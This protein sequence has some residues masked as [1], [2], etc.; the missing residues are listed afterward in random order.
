MA[1]DMQFGDVEQAGVLHALRPDRNRHF[2]VA[3]CGRPAEEDLPI[4]VDLDAMREMEEH[5]LSD[6]RVEL[7]GVML[8]GQH[9]DEQGRPFV[10][11]TDC[12]RAQHYQS[13]K[14]SF[15][16]THDTWQEI[17]RQ[18]DEFPENLQMVG[19]YH[20]HPSWGVFLSS[21]DMFI[22]QNFFNRPL[23]LA[24][25]I[26]PCRQDRGFFQ[27]VGQRK[28]RT[29]RTGGFYLVSS[30]FREEELHWY[31]A[32]L[33]EETAM[34][35]D[36]DRGYPPQRMPMPV[37]NISEGRPGWVG[38]AVVGMLVIQVFFTML[39]AWR[40]IAGPG[41]D[42]AAAPNV[43]LAEL[44]KRVEKLAEKQEEARR[45]SVKQEVLDDVLRQIGE[46]DGPERLVSELLD[47][48]E[49]N[50]RLRAA[51]VGYETVEKQNRELAKSLA[52]SQAKAENQKKQVD[53]LT[54]DKRTIEEE[55]HEKERKI[56]KLEETIH[57]LKYP[58]SDGEGDD[59]AD[60]GQ[61]AAWWYSKWFWVIVAAGVLA[62]LGIGGALISSRTRH[63]EDEGLPDS[64][65]RSPT[66][67]REPAREAADAADRPAELPGEEPP[68]E[69]G[70]P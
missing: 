67:P 57:R 44:E 65:G 11:V 56:A 15:K 43:Q 20:T 35:G 5:A 1:S 7:G 52:E 6:T 40:L 53:E 9:E 13:T 51:S 36:T 8:G 58:P 10:F 26:D 47:E 49:K 70:G 46:P 3:A 29:R 16:F 55:V 68:D 62:A 37:V 19:W 2:A 54:E 21:L 30:R 66:E 64:S 33:E 4:F 50:T 39:V 27:W 23:D 63:W 34:R 22:C 28:A 14:G 12:L 61:P 41:G 60:A 32:C 69:R 24:L 18:R 38:V 31:A 48:K 25:V 45:L 42:G 59:A 17:T